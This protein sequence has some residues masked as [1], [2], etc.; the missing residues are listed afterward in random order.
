MDTEK[1]LEDKD[2]GVIVGRFQVHELHVAHRQII[3]SVMANH[4]KVIIFLGVTP[5]QVT[6]NNPLDFVARKEM[7][8]DAFPSITVMPLPDTPDDKD[9][10]KELDSRIREA[11]PVNSIVMYGGRDSFIKYYSGNFETRE[12]EQTIFVSGTE[13]R[14][15]VSREVKSSADFRAGVI[16]A[17]YNQYSK[18]F[19]TVDVAILQDDK[20]L[21]G[22]KPNHA[23]Y[24]FLGGFT[25][26][27]DDSYED[28][29]KREVHEE[30]NIEIGDVTYLGS[31]KIDDWRYRKEEDKIITHLFTGK[32]VFGNIEPKDDISEIKWFNLK[33][34][35]EDDFV[36]EHAVLF[37]L[38]K[39]KYIDKI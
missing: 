6:K 27:S 14:K 39:T 9:W 34:L 8:L 36:P 23:K 33:E 5:A 3:E 4:K 29:A 22:K 17:A 12:L 15:N 16:Y 18:V 35:K 20:V 31:A 10:S 37:R 25:D 2:V 13:V 24:R 38:F 30:A 32:Y 28:A 21:L 19:A 7:I 11:C 1:K 26:P